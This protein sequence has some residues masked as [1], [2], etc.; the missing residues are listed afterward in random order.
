ME[1]HHDGH[2]KGH[3]VEV[4]GDQV[5]LVVVEGDPEEL[6]ELDVLGDEEGVEVAE[7]EE[8]VEEE[9]QVLPVPVP[10]GSLALLGALGDEEEEDDGEDHVEDVHFSE[11]EPE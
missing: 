7:D 8:G 3:E 11:G 5:V 10:E 9:H 6:E 4:L 2:Q 1:C